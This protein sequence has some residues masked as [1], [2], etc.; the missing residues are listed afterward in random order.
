VEPAVESDGTGA[1]PASWETDVVLSDGQTVHV[2]P[3]V[4]ED[5]D[6]L[7]QFHS[8]QS[9]ES[10]YFR[11]F[12][13]RPQLSE[14]DLHRFTHV[15]HHDRVAFVALAGDDLIA[16]ARYERYRGTDTAEVAF[17]IDDAHHGRGLATLLLEYLAAAGRERGIRR[18]AATTL[19]HNRKM[20]GVFSAAGYQVSSRLDDGV[21]EVGFDIDPTV[22]SQAAVDRRERRAEAASV[23]RLLEPRSV[24]VVGV[25]RSG[26]GLGAEVHRNLASNGFRGPLYAVNRGGGSVDGAPMFE[27]VR[28]LPE[29][30]DL[31][32][33]ATPAADV[34]GI[35][36]ECGELGAGGVVVVSAGF[37]EAGPDGEQ[38]EAAAVDA[39]RHHGLRL[40][41]P[42]CLGV[43]NTDPEI[44]LD[45][46]IA[47]VVPRRGSAAVLAESGTLAAAIIDHAVRVD[48][49]ISTLV[50]AGNRADISATDLL[51]YWSEDE[52][53]GVVLLYLAARDLQPR[54]V[55]AARATSMELPVAALH[56]SMSPRGHGDTRGDDRAKAQAMFRQTG[57]IGVDTLE[58]L[59][60]I[61]RLASDQAV[62]AGHG[63][64]VIGN[65]DG[66]V[67][68]AAD[69][70]LAAGLELV[71]F[72]LEGPHHGNPIDLSYQ[73]DAAAYRAALERVSA[74]PRVHSILVIHT[75][76]HLELDDELIDVVLDA[77]AAAPGIALA[78]TMLGAA[79]RGR[80]ERDGVAVPIF[81]FPEDAARALGRLADHHTWR[82][83]V[84]TT[85]EAIDRPDEQDRAAAVLA[86][87]HPSEDGRT[88]ALDLRQQSELL[89][90]Y[91]V[92]VIDR[93]EVHDVDA[94]V[95]AAR[96]IGYPVALKARTRD[97]L[98]RSAAS[99]VVLDLGD[100]EQLRTAWQR[101]E[102]VLGDGLAPAVVQRFVQ[103]GIDVGVTIRRDADGSGTVRVGLG[104]PA[105]IARDHEL[106]VL[107]LTLSDA[108]SLVA[109]S[110]VG[111]VLTDPLDRIAIVEL[112]HNLASLV[113]DHD[114]VR[115]LRVDPVVCSPAAALVADAEVLVGA[116]IDDFDVRRLD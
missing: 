52:A 6:R 81:R 113:V 106:A 16:V 38:L 58:Q 114:E 82:S 50:A 65:S 76:P 73:A 53:T 90:A 62:P 95:E 34:P 17:F 18:F 54:F 51:S 5:A 86:S 48:L 105:A 55:R 93:L 69:A 74:D 70:C 14:R 59:F 27:S 68:L 78:V 26:T 31:V 112:V 11:Y 102:A 103:Q 57:V 43:V 80:L 98:T 60:D 107:P 75:P 10:I 7:V 30:V 3:I 45:A 32:V 56:T 40:L 29:P 89:G 115:S 20:L 44:R 66:A 64:V 47:P 36:A 88:V 87:V 110:P 85:G 22:A 92:E 61:G 100:E 12:S 99:G 72:G 97:R 19:P 116:P 71:P 39:A 9:P 94:A 33:I 79:G 24:A 21:V 83:S 13:P 8:R 23:R 84:D 49:G 4:P 35:V 104:G 1:Y 46:T 108:S 67:S 37:S 15:D 96:R 2:R 77:S 63:V 41:G 28:D 109:T 42:N 111:R 101:M 25:G 91:H